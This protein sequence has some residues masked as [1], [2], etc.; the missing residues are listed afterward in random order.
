VKPR[1]VGIGEV[2]WDLL[3]SGPALGGAPANFACHAQ[4]L[5][6]AA[7]L[8][9]RVG[10]DDLG[11]EAVRLLA[12]RG[13]DLSGLSV[14]PVRA[15]GSVSVS[16]SPD[17]QPRFVIHADVAWDALRAGPAEL[18][19]VASA[20]AVCFGTLAQRDP[21]SREA[22]R[23]CVAAAPAACLRVL[24]VNLRAP[25]HDERV[26]RESLA[27]ADVLKL[28]ETELPA[29]SGPLGIGGTEEHRVR[30]LAEAW[31]L[32]AVALTLG[33]AGSAL[34]LDGAWHTE[35]GRA[36]TVADTVG[37]GDA[38]SA[39]LVIGLLRGWEGPRILDAATGVAAHVCT[40]QG[41]TPELPG[42]VL[43]PFRD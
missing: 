18:A 9:S 28:N 16:L 43:R 7:A 6:A 40:R 25:F 11:R 31:E 39:A 10:D 20:D 26:L 12:A 23:R 14:D 15:T 41:A 13:L 33:A 5:G 4:A 21:V 32:R 2:L 19:V 27:L 36:V 22:V 38:F 30:A 1:V 37:A 3:P 29:L 17:G 35:P 34:L 8:V 42:E 24:D